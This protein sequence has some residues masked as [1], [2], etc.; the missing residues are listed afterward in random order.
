MRDRTAR[1]R[2]K[3]KEARRQSILDAAGRLLLEQGFSATTMDEIAER[4]ELSKGTLYLYFSG[5]QEL[6]LALLVEASRV[7]V[8]EM[9]ASYDP[10]A[11][12]L[13]Q[14]THVMQAY[15][16]FYRRRPDYFRLL[17]VIEHQ[18]Y[19]SEVG[20]ELRAAWTDLGR[21]GIEIPVSII[22]SAIEQGAVRPCDPW[23]MAVSLWA[24]VT[25]VIVL[26]GQEI[27]WGFLGQL[28]QEKLVLSTVQNFWRA[29]ANP[30]GDG[31][32][33]TPA[34]KPVS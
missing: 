10:A 22:Q 9:K 12:P 18:P 23:M 4:A 13:D 21:Q 3:E 1:R 14:L 29:I 32:P 2:L 25:G 8:A 28:D 27:R 11:R 20:E 19:R 31:E 24:S 33:T 26:T 5:K 16:E 34:G 15:Y 7:F 30:N 6:C 17:F